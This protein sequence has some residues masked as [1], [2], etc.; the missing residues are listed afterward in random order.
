MGEKM[1]KKWEFLDQA[2][3]TSPLHPWFSWELGSPFGGDALGLFWKGIG[4][5]IPFRGGGS[6]GMEDQGGIPKLSLSILV[7]MLLQNQP[8]P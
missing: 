1:G 3:R 4:S 5:S 8:L 2:P 7:K 6:P